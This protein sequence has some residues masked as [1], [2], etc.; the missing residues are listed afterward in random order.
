VLQAEDRQNDLLACA[1]RW[2]ASGKAQFT[3]C[4]AFTGSRSKA[5][6]GRTFPRT[7]LDAQTRSTRWTWIYINTGRKLVILNIFL[8]RAGPQIQM[9][10]L[11]FWSEKSIRKVLHF[12]YLWGPRD[13]KS[14]VC[15]ERHEI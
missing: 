5:V 8:I 13:Q 10:C 11:K 3:L 14:V 4:P 6:A 9:M 2:F 1:S 12:D 15:S 7:S